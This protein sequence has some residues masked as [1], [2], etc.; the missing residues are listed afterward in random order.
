MRNGWIVCALVMALTGIGYAR[1]D[2]QAKAADRHLGTWVGT[3]ASSGEGGG[4]GE[5]EVTIE[6]GKQ[7][8]LAG[9]LKATGGE[10]GHT[11][12]FKTLSFDG[13][14]MSATYDYPLGEGGEIAMEATFEG[15]TA[16]G[17]WTLHPPGQ[18]GQD[19]RGTWTVTKK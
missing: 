7:G 5:L 1:G 13:N 9:R 8:A 3:W 19:A 16:K 18:G 6:N 11:A 17:T 12:V 15:S 2:G 10:S 14:K 4:A